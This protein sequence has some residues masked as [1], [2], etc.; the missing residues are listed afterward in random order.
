M[1]PV[2]IF[3]TV[4]GVVQLVGCGYK[5]SKEL[6]D[7]YNSSS[8][9]SRSR[10]QLAEETTRLRD[11]LQSIQSPISD[12]NTTNQSAQSTTVPGPVQHAIDETIL[13]AQAAGKMLL[14][15]LEN[16]RIEPDI[17][18]LKRATQAFR[19]FR[20]RDKTPAL[21]KRFEQLQ[22]QLQG[23]L[24]IELR[25]L[26]QNLLTGQIE[27]FQNLSAAQQT[28]VSE[29]QAN[30]TQ[31]KQLSEAMSS[32]KQNVQSQAQTTQ[33]Q[34]VNEGLETRNLISSQAQQL[35]IQL[36]GL[37][38]GIRKMD[39]ESE[40]RQLLENLW[41]PE[42]Y[43]R[44]MQ[45][46]ET[47]RETFKWIFHTPESDRPWDDFPRWLGSTDA[48]Y[49]ISGKPGSG[50]STLMRYILSER[51]ADVEKVLRDWSGSHTLVVAEVFFWN[52]GSTLQKSS[53]GLLRCLLHQILKRN[54][55]FT[56]RISSSLLQNSQYSNAL[57][58]SLLED[59]L[60]EVLSNSSECIC[61]FIDGLDEFED[62][63]MA[64]GKKLLDIFGRLQEAT[65]KR[66]KFCFSSRPLQI[67]CWT[68]K[69]VK[70]LALHHLTKKDIRKHVQQSISEFADESMINTIVNR[71]NGVFLWVDLAV[72]S[73][74]AAHI[75]G[76][77]N[78]QISK[79][80]KSLPSE[81]YQMYD[82]MFKSIE[83]VY[84][85]DVAVYFAMALKHEQGHP[86][87]PASPNPSI[88][89][90][91]FATNPKYW[92][93]V[94]SLWSIETLQQISIGC[95][96]LELWIKSRTC[97][98]LEVRELDS[99]EDRHW[100]WLN[101]T[102]LAERRDD[103]SAEVAALLTEILK[104]FRR[105]R[106]VFMHRRVA[107]FLKDQKTSRIV[108][109]MSKFQ[110]LQETL[111][112]NLLLIAS[113]RA[114]VHVPTSTE[115]AMSE[116]TIRPILETITHL[117]WHET[118]YRQPERAIA[119][120]LKEFCK[121]AADDT[122]S[123][124]GWRLA[125]SYFLHLI[126]SWDMPLTLSY[127]LQKDQNRLKRTWPALRSRL[128]R[129]AISGRL[130]ADEALVFSD[131]A[132]RSIDMLLDE[133]P[134]PNDQ[135]RLDCLPERDANKSAWQLYVGSWQLHRNS[136]VQ[137]VRRDIQRLIALGSDVD[138]DAEALIYQPTNYSSTILHFKW[139]SQ[140]N[141]P[142]IQALY[143]FQ[144]YSARPYLHMRECE[145]RK[146]NP[147]DK[148]NPAFAEGVIASYLRQM[149]KKIAVED[150]ETLPNTEKVPSVTFRDFETSD[151]QLN[152]SLSAVIEGEI[153]YFPPERVKATIIEDR[154]NEYFANPTED[155]EAGPVV[156]A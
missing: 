52:A 146:G 130:Y 1:D 32:L 60:R 131:P 154:V 71:A 126:A 135:T 104:S 82:H 151:G 31:I 153:V 140:C 85:D 46:K 83:D 3:S 86:E 88:M 90:I 143:G 6:L 43:A 7:A 2:T 103:E 99:Y 145:L 149:L 14:E 139:S 62:G 63:S 129:C 141:A 73:L 49:W 148:Y 54:P 70:Q 123:L 47:A 113:A 133:K 114:A 24:I 11:L 102:C 98:I 28:L 150:A 87:P 105:K 116:E 156:E 108:Q 136:S 33:A 110:K 34:V 21:Q 42:M 35:Q 61:L 77:T 69:E 44:E 68:F 111:R 53:E 147:T 29:I 78:E 48:R 74:Q 13:K 16:T 100:S 23:Y 40:H 107:D 12:V 96:R 58:S 59:M 51:R 65:D 101:D 92:E 37:G 19:V 106:V 76:D 30:N 121:R 119:W 17:R 128:L 50:K 93:E 75:N 81:L 89:Q 125:H 10:E 142:F 127:F 95:R 64:S 94:L 132:L 22:Q 18:G 66:V 36:T 120:R 26:A 55:A 118:I 4:C 79:R 91:F 38:S 15:Q 27:G 144:S 152:L 25:P 8:G 112:Y 97:G 134:D 115:E 155:V 45:I 39:F 109:T 84:Y 72:K 5:I 80:L 124:H 20:N 138:E 41:F 137:A 57:P 122:R 9:L 117:K 67:F 56:Q